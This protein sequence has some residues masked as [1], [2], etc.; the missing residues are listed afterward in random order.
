MNKIALWASAHKIT[1]EQRASLEEKGFEIN[2]LSETDPVLFEEITN[3]NEFSNRA[4]LAVKLL[5]QPAHWL[6]QPAGDPSLMFSLGA[7]GQMMMETGEPMVH[8]VVFAFTKRE[9]K[10]VP[11]PDGS[12]R[13]ISVFKF[14]GW[15]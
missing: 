13:K 12:V 8:R 5:I 4:A 2:F 10:D 7:Q 11:Q 6:V 14:E 1:E 9:S 15:V 3:L